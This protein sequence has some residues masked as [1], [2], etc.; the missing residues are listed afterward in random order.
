MKSKKSLKKLLSLALI[1]AM[2]LGMTPVFTVGAAATVSETSSVPLYTVTATQ[3][4]GVTGTT[5]TQGISL[6]FALSSGT[7][8][9]E[10]TLTKEQIKII[11]PYKYG[12]TEM[13]EISEDVYV[14]PVA[15]LL[16]YSGEEDDGNDLTWY[17]PFGAPATIP[18]G[19]TGAYQY[20]PTNA[21]E[22]FNMLAKNGSKMEI[23]IANG[24]DYT[25]ATTTGSDGKT[26]ITC[27][28]V[29]Y[30]ENIII[31]SGQ[32][33][34]DSG[35]NG[36]VD[37]RG[38]VLGLYTENHQPVKTFY[39]GAVKLTGALIKNTGGTRHTTAANYDDRWVIEFEPGSINVA[40]GESI[41]VSLEG[42]GQYVLA[43]AAES[44]AE[45][46]ELTTLYDVYSKVAV[47]TNS[48]KNIID[49]NLKSVRQIGGYLYEDAGTGNSWVE[50]TTKGI[51]LSFDKPLI[52][53][54]VKD[55]KDVEL[56]AGSG[57][58]LGALTDY[59]DADARTWYLPITDFDDSKTDGKYPLTLTIGA[60]Q[61]VTGLAGGNT[62]YGQIDAT[63]YRVYIPDELLKDGKLALDV[64]QK[65]TVPVTY[66]L[67][68]TGGED[69]KTD[70]TGL[71]LIISANQ[72]LDGFNNSF[73]NLVG[74]RTSGATLVPSNGGKTLTYNYTLAGNIEAPAAATGDSAAAADSDD[75]IATVSI[76][77]WTWEGTGDD[78][79]KITRFD[80][81]DSA[82]AT[83]CKDTRPHLTIVSAKGS[84]EYDIT[85]KTDMMGV[86]YLGR[87]DDTGIEFTLSQ[88]GKIEG[89][90]ASAFT[91]TDPDT[92][93]VVATPT[94]TGAGN[95]LTYNT[96]NNV[97]TLK[98]NN[99]VGDG[100]EVPFVLK[101]NDGTG[102]VIDN[103]A[104]GTLSR[105]AR[106]PLSL[107]SAVE[108][109][110]VEDEKNSES[111]LL[112]LSDNFESSSPDSFDFKNQITL[113]VIGSGENSIR[114]IVEP[115]YDELTKEL[116]KN[117][118]RLKITGWN[119]EGDQE[120]F[121]S[122][123]DMNNHRGNYKV[124]A[125][126]KSVFLYRVPPVASQGRTL[127]SVSPQGIYTG[128]KIKRVTLTGVLRGDI[129]AVESVYVRP[130]GVEDPTRWTKLELPAPITTAVTEYA[131]DVANVPLF[132]TPG[133]YE[134][135]F[136]SA[137]GYISEW[138]PIIVSHNSIYSQDGYGILVI[139]QNSDKS[140]DL[141]PYPS[142]SSMDDGIQGK[143]P[144]MIFRGGVLK[145]DNNNYR[146]QSGAILNNVLSYYD[147]D[148]DS[149][150]EISKS[151]GDIRIYATGGSLRWKNI[152]ITADLPLGSSK[153]EFD[154]VLDADNT[155]KTKRVNADGSETSGT[156]I[157]I[158]TGFNDFTANFLVGKVE[159]NAYELYDGECAISGE[160]MLGLPDWLVGAAYAGV[161]LETMLLDNTS[162]IPPLKATGS[163]E[164]RP[165]G[166]LGDSVSDMI[167]GGAFEINIDTLPESN[168]KRIGA[169]GNLD[170]ADMLYV[171]GELVMAWGKLGGVTV[172]I[173]DK[174]SLFARVP[175][176][177]GV[178]LVPPSILAYINGFG[179]GVDGIA[180]TLFGNF[181]Y[182]PP[183]KLSAYGAIVDASGQLFSINKAEFT[184][185]LG[186]ISAYAREAKILKVLTLSN[187][188]YEYG[189]TDSTIPA[190]SGLPSVDT[191]FSIGGE[192]SADA[193][194]ILEIKGS[195]K[196][197]VRLRGNYMTDAL[198]G[199]TQDC[200]EAGGFTTPD[201]E[202]ITALY[203]AI[204]FNGRIKA[205]AEISL[206][207]LGTLAGATGEL[208][209]SKTSIS[210][211]V[212]GK[213]W[214]GIK[215]K[216][217]IK[218]DFKKAKFSVISSA[219][220]SASSDDGELTVTNL[221]DAGGY[222]P[223]GGSSRSRL[224]AATP[225]ATAGQ[226]ALIFSDKR[227]NDIK[228][229]KDG[230]TEAIAT[231]TDADLK[232]FDTEETADKEKGTLTL[233][234]LVPEDGTY[235]FK[236]IEIDENGT[237]VSPQVETE[238]K[239]RLD[240][241][242]AKKDQIAT[243]FSDTEYTK[244]NVYKTMLSDGKRLLT[245]ITVNDDSLGVEDDA[246]SKDL[247]W[248]DTVETADKS[249][250]DYS[251]NW[252]VPEDGTYTFK[253]VTIV[254]GE[255]I[256][257]E[258]LFYGLTE[259]APLPE[260]LTVTPTVTDGSIKTDW[261]LNATASET[262]EI[263]EDTLYT[264]LFLID[265]QT[266]D[267]V[268]DLTAPKDNINEAP[269]E[270][271]SAASEASTD[272]AVD[273]PLANVET[274]SFT[275]VLPDSLP[276]GKYYI[277]AELITK[278]TDLV[279]L[280][281]GT[282]NATNETI[283]DYVTVSELR[284][285]EFTYTN[286]QSL[287]APTGVTVANA[288]N[289][290]IRVRWNEVEGADGYRVT[291]LDE[292]GKEVPGFTSLEAIDAEGKVAT[293]ITI[294]GGVSVSGDVTEGNLVPLLDESGQPVLDEEGNPEYTYEYTNDVVVDEEGNTLIPG[295]QSGLPFGKQYS[296]EVHAYKNL[297]I[298]PEPS[299]AA[300]SR[301]ADAE[302]DE[303]A[304]LV[305]VLGNPG[306]ATLNELAEPHIP[307]LTVS[308]E[309][310]NH[311]TA[312]DGTSY[313]AT[314]DT[315][316]TLNITTGDVPATITVYVEEAV[317][318][319]V[320]GVDVT[321]N[322]FVPKFT[323]EPLQTSFEA[324][325]DDLGEDG[326]YNLRIT[327]TTE[328][329][330]DSA[331][332]GI[333]SAETS[334]MISL[335]TVAPVLEVDADS[336][337]LPANGELSIKGFTELGAGVTMNGI[338]LP[339][340]GG[341]FPVEEG[342]YIIIKDIPSDEEG[343]SSSS[344]A[345]AEAAASGAYIVEL[346]A[347][348]EAGNTTSRIFDVVQTEAQ[349]I[350]PNPVY[351]P[352]PPAPEIVTGNEGQVEIAFTESEGQVKLE[353]PAEKVDELI[354][355]AVE[356]KVEINVTAIEGATSAEIPTQALQEIADADL[357]LEI[358][359]PGGTASLDPEAAA[360]ILEKAEGDT[361][362]IIV[363]EIPEVS[364]KELNS[365][366]LAT[367]AVGDTVYDI[368]IIS[369][370]VEIHDFTGNIRITVPYSGK[371]PVKAWYMGDKGK[372]EK[373]SGTYDAV[374]GTFT[375]TVPHLSY[376]VVGYD[377]TPWQN[378]FTDVTETDWFYEFVQFVNS[379]DPTLMNGTSA[380]LFSPG[381][382]MSRAM[383]VTVLWR[384]EGS[385][386]PSGLTRTDLGEFDDVASDAYYY[387]AVK[388][389]AQN[390][391]VN[392]VG[393]GRF[394]PES[395]ISRQDIAVI[396]HRFA[397]FKA[398]TMLPGAVLDSY[399]DAPDISA[400]AL[401]AMKWANAAQ[402]ITGRTATTL[403]PLN[404]ATRAEV[405]KILTQFVSNVY[406]K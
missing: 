20:A 361:L 91:I 217:G 246:S 69:G 263:E 206:G 19:G 42:W 135:S 268:L 177:G 202:V 329:G 224:A 5:E 17:I 86:S 85:S 294:Q 80:A 249:S 136:E 282:E 194:G 157:V 376:Y 216:I 110:S 189:I 233:N 368:S 242:A 181:N 49:I 165:G 250:G 134:I 83:L 220:R 370:G 65:N 402:L 37:S 375:F 204:E 130:E 169:A 215:K 31:E 41:S 82:T 117:Q 391:I 96:A 328:N 341:R 286:S 179:G 404:T 289:G 84:G 399:T 26:A 137:D 322:E 256:E 389:A 148:G 57:V 267:I 99:I 68:Q 2:L 293:E 48:L 18:T 346:F 122:I 386:L 53:K 304:V 185:G 76:S 305:P 327:A 218:F 332:N 7:A 236:G 200:I 196:L 159:L 107:E 102:Y 340:E 385:P 264:R 396:F 262:P 252:L 33:M 23:I 279:A 146:V 188:G 273:Y 55:V 308:V 378:P 321:E 258:A 51:L 184:F 152:P 147:E 123:R 38:F 24:V 296:F 269:A 16:G 302:P 394:A 12:G 303:S 251:A 166:F 127:D 154:I 128:S 54:D 235:T 113:N 337:I 30:R 237:R 141:T 156:P 149:A 238:L 401:D 195:T 342:E 119:F 67:E 380:T 94:G 209:I 40:N 240:V 118:V 198:A 339:V 243:I 231:I 73:I 384:L 277:S 203:N 190:K 388:W 311:I 75:I 63:Q 121:V 350:A 406:N 334:V 172:V 205:S 39:K 174:L 265:A 230:G 168:P 225:K 162:L 306:T 50:S 1:L 281:E 363:E 132:R 366:Q 129:S 208:A 104:S 312:S 3:Y 371:L 278:T 13:T 21:T 120:F 395:S 347:F 25:L 331:E 45:S 183:V 160:F 161:D 359:L 228:I 232:W 357:G 345:A 222:M 59:G 151:G 374:T 298:T 323:S 239:C 244:I 10:F 405:A 27:D 109:G 353:L 234:W 276:S 78:V 143:N 373:I 14:M 175:A 309:G 61:T 142:E 105:D 170:I 62:S 88:R 178:P 8:V 313:Y 344:Q 60:S 398:S 164:F 207:R 126:R 79:G 139:T 72:A 28:P 260:Y 138:R 358:I 291:V 352:S 245:T 283:V 131:L 383:L 226:I 364:N 392:G 93:E 253:G 153:H 266:D 193:A 261:T 272:L 300:A 318:T 324:T 382:P 259:V 6:T 221:I 173:P 87:F 192:I 114:Y 317:T 316:P 284:S 325:L 292:E 29:V 11:N 150:I 338:T 349:T 255:E 108:E 52:L 197:D 15:E 295:G 77:D 248:F 299:G 393:G 106:T 116:I 90:A 288:G 229:Y 227:Y 140:F 201:K 390:G 163:A 92:R 247:V 381:S 365:E 326:V 271:T 167:G 369:N 58:T 47:N 297:S 213:I 214:P 285:A 44:A 100:G 191:Y 280:F 171:E 180:D 46:I 315:T 351:P 335:D 372:S 307:E 155:Y 403:A 182:V 71:K 158:K 301:I 9:S 336:L 210:G 310:G 377:D 219:S 211:K 74:A 101:I 70:S 95:G 35:L 319:N 145:T 124:T 333:D 287:P 241:S 34:V 115:V 111:I 274:K 64:Y 186:S 4:G 43:G 343:D 66:T 144:I 103:T 199:F 125:E 36:T 400:Y 56:V 98:I 362:E 314:N 275:A 354:E 360:D 348:D 387:L 212:T 330:I 112:T 176:P 223:T 133:D 81:I 397:Q 97:W 355:K 187:V 257:S 270:G 367:L 379:Y 22:Y 89:L 290:A 32:F 356:D 320:D 254:D